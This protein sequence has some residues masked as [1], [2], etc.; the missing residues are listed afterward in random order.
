MAETRY[1]DLYLHLKNHGMDVYPPQYKTGECTS[2]YIVIN[3]A[4]VLRFDGYSSTQ[5]LYDI[6][7]YVPK[8]QYTSIEI[9]MD[10]IR[11]W[12]KELPMF[13]P[14]YNETAPY[15]DDTVKGYM[16]SIQY[17]NYRKM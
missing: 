13:K 9:L 5:H 6:M 16:T 12:M 2:P 3:G 4:G 10:Q 1:E 14:T 17:V 11:D 15:Y 8:N 7:L